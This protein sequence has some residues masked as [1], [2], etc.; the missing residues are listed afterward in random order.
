MMLQLHPIL[1]I[2]RQ[3]GT[4]FLQYSTA[5][6]VAG[7]LKLLLLLGYEIYHKI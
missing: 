3:R 6:L 5:S 7:I 1:S 2:T 4:I